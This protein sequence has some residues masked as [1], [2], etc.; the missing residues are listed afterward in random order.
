MTMLEKATLALWR[1]REERLPARLRRRVPDEMDRVS[2]ALELTRQ[3]V[4]AVLAAI[5]DPDR[6]MVRAGDEIDDLQG[7]R[8]VWQTM[9]DAILAE[10]PE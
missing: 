2:G 4:R 10:K 3:E 1:V 9:I 8:P 6:G 5:R 7:S